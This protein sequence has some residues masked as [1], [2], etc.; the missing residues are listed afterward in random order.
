M[1]DGVA[2]SPFN[3]PADPPWQVD[4]AARGAPPVET[5]TR[6]RLM[7]PPPRH[8]RAGPP[9]LEFAGV[10]SAQIDLRRRLEEQNRDDRRR[11]GQ[12]VYD[13]TA[14]YQVRGKWDE[15]EGGDANALSSVR[16]LQFESR[17]ESG[18]LQRAVKVGPSEYDL[19]LR[20]DKGCGH[21]QWHYFMVRN[22]KHG[23]PYVFNIVNFVKNKSLYNAGL[24]PLTYSEKEARGKR[25]GIGWHRTGSKCVYYQRGARYALTFETTFKYDGDTC[26]F[27]HCYPYTYSDGQLFLASLLKDPE[28]SK[29]Y[30]FLPNAR[31]AERC[32]MSLLLRACMKSWR[33]K[34]MRAPKV[35]YPNLGG[36]CRCK[37]SELCRSLAG[38]VKMASTFHDH[39]LR[40]IYR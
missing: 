34:A 39:C 25:G 4:E 32:P 11:D 19:Y 21:V 7:H 22:M 40:R 24:R 6:R 36:L 30:V 15:A 13:D 35:L 8:I 17:F 26:F 2:W 20:P 5:G 16:T 1:T 10:E 23:V 18:N 33:N 9:G 29:S 3:L 31:G 12:V 28:R 37:R 14:P 38:D 27:A